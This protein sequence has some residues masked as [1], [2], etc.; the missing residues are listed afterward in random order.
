MGRDSF[1]VVCIHGAEQWRTFLR[2]SR[3]KITTEVMKRLRISEKKL[4]KE[5]GRNMVL[6]DIAVNIRKMILK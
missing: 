2:E 4:K 3:P 1:V 5:Q 6:T